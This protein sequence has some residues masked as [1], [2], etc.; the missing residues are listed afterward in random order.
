MLGVK[1]RS[2]LHL[3]LWRTG[4]HCLMK[5][6]D[7]VVHEKQR[8]DSVATKVEPFLHLALLVNYVHKNYWQS[9][10][11]DSPGGVHHPLG[12]SPIYYRQ[13]DQALATVLHCW[14][15][16]TPITAKAPSTGY[17]EG[18][19]QVQ[20]KHIQTSWT[21]SQ[22][23]LNILKRMK[24]GSSVPQPGPK[25]HYFFFIQALTNTQTLLSSSLE[26]TFPEHTL[27]SPFLTM[28]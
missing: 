9:V 15:G 6:T 20:K 28:G 13:C 21:N 4:G 1:S 3:K 2:L 19:N 24:S 26:Q 12:A 16:Q 25:P 17:P 8:W 23:Y 22:A 7:H 18:H 5:P 14:K 11:K 10:T 27:V